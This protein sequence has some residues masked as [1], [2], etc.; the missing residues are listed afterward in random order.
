VSYFDEPSSYST[1]IV[2]RSSGIAY[3][4]HLVGAGEQRFVPGK[5]KR[6]CKMRR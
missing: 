2:S 6:H 5:A 1:T 3:L 4:D